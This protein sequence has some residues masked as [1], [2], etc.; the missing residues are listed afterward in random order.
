[1]KKLLHKLDPRRPRQKAI[2]LPASVDH[3]RP[4]Y[5]LGLVIIVRDEACYIEEWLE[6]HLMQG[7]NHVIV[8]DNHSTD[9]TV[10]TLAPWVREGTATIV[11]WNRFHKRINN[12]SLAYAHAL[13]NF[14][15]WFKWLGFLDADEFL[16]PAGDAN[17]PEVLS[18]FEQLPA[19]GVCWSMF[20]NSGHS[21][22][23]DG[24][25]ISNYMRKA[26][27]RQ[28][29][30]PVHAINVKSVVRPQQI[31][32]VQGAHMFHVHDLGQGA[33]L[34]AETWLPKH[35]KSAA[36]G[37]MQ[38]PLQLNHYY[39][40]SEEEFSAKLAKG[41]VRGPGFFDAARYHDVKTWIDRDT[42]EDRSILRFVPALEARLARRRKP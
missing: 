22:R 31:T 33:Y 3:G 18:G 35:R 7:V 1:M 32:A 34:D 20:G 36:A 28:G 9:A 15:P 4:K 8:Y 6:F 42:I 29:Q 10:E 17:L 21:H 25:V 38:G 5:D 26:V 41:S 40:R 13:A 24:L 16:F 23:P 12:Q 11:P 19:I 14:G 30:A 2:P 39:T 27:M 37:Q